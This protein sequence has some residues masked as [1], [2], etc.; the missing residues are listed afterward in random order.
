MLKHYEMV[1]SLETIPPH[2]ILADAIT[3]VVTANSLAK[4]KEAAVR[5]AQIEK[6]GRKVLEV[7]GPVFPPIPVR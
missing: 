6:P 2:P 5:Q 1:V 4:A 7:S 3:V